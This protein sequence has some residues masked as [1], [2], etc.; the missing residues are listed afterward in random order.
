MSFI[1]VFDANY[2]MSKTLPGFEREYK[3]QE[4]FRDFFGS[5]LINYISEFLRPNLCEWNWL[6]Y[7]ILEQLNMDMDTS[8]IIYFVI[9]VCE[10]NYDFLINI[11]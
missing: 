7:H 9:R 1:R 6:I 8:Y 10:T 2:D 4:T 5:W 3:C 11:N